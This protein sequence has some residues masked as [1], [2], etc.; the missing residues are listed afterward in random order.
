MCRKHRKRPRD[1]AAAAP[2][3][4]AAADAPVNTVGGYAA[5]LSEYANKGVTGLPEA[6]DS[7]RVLTSKLSKLAD[8]V[9]NAKK[10][11]VL[12]GAGIST[13]AGIPDFRGPKGI[14]TLEDEEKKRTKRRKPPRKLRARRWTR[15]RPARAST[16][17]ATVRLRGRLLDTVLDWDD[18]LPDSEWLPATRHFEDADLAITLGTSLRIVPAGE[19]PL[20]SK[21]FVIVNHLQ[22]TPY[23]DKAGLVIRARRRR[24]GGAARGAGVGPAATAGAGG[25]AGGGGGSGTDGGGGA[26]RGT[27]GG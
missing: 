5:R 14:W 12:T 8:L 15:A 23:D 9:K 26:A 20:T 18:G 13:S 17:G 7:K 4:P 27:G 22:P 16:H 21:N 1:A 6:E 19:L 10:I 2:P 24:H 11:A 3:P 25:A